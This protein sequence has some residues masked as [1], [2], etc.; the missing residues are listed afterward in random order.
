MMPIARLLRV[1][2]TRGSV[3]VRTWERSS[4]K[5]TSRGSSLNARHPGE[6]FESQNTKT[7]SAQGPQGAP[8]PSS[9]RPNCPAFAKLPAGSSNRCDAK[10]APTHLQLRR[11][12]SD[13]FTTSLR[14]QLVKGRSPKIR[15]PTLDEPGKLV[16]RPPL[17]EWSAHDHRSNN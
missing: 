5:V 11:D 2:R 8:R 13:L 9:S 14:K 1:V 12:N 17:L 10:H 7:R 15:G 4:P 6:V 16:M 3:P